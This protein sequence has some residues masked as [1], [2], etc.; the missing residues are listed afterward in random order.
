M[1]TV[2]I[3]QPNFL[4]WLGYFH[5]LLNCDVFIFLD[6]AQ[7]PRGK[8]FVS[9]VSVKSPGGPLWLTV[10]VQGKGSF[11][12]IKNTV[13]VDPEK[14][15]KKHL[16]TLQSCYARAPFFAEYFP[17]IQQVYDLECSLLADFNISLIKR[18]AG[19][20]SSSP[21]MVRSSELN[22]DY[23]GS[24]DHL[25]KL[26]RCMGGTRYLTGK[27]RGTLR[28]L[29]Q[30]AFAREGIEVVF[31]SFVHPEYPQLW[32]EFIP[33]LSIVDLIFNCGE[34]SEKILLKKS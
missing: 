8:S 13:M 25:V 29:D 28:H 18:L 34:Q 4:P 33:N 11:L 21:H 24:L 9:R 32:G 16:K 12:P 15:R 30:S 23:D 20:F 19:V 10:P 2:A 31:Q 14:W 5:K 6:D 26:V 27:G 1:T 17:A 22:L 7:F 3:H